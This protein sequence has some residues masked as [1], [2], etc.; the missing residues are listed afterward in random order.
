MTVRLRTPW[1]FASKIIA[2]TSAAATCLIFSNAAAANSHCQTENNDNIIVDT[3]AVDLAWSSTRVNL[4][5][6]TQ[7]QDQLVAYYNATRNMVV[8]HRR[9]TTRQNTYGTPWSFKQLDT[10]LGWDNH[11]SVVVGVSP[12]RHFHVT[13]NMHA[14]QLVYYKTEHPGD[15]R[16]LK[17]VDVM[18]DADL[19][20]RVTY[21]NFFHAD[22][23]TLLLRFRVG[24]SGNGDEVYYRY[25]AESGQWTKALENGFTDGEGQQNAYISS[26]VRGP[27][28]KF[29][30][31]WVWRTDPGSTMNT[32]VSYAR[33]Q[34]YIYWEDAYG[35]PL[36]L[37][38]T[39]G[40]TPV[41]APVPLDNGM[42]N[43]H[44]KVGFDPQGRPLVTYVQYDDNKIAQAYIAR[45]EGQSW[46]QYQL[47][48][49]DRVTH[50]KNRRGALAPTS[51]QMRFSP[52]VNPN[53]TVSVDAHLFGQPKTLMLD[54]ETL[55]L[56]DTCDRQPVPSFLKAWEAQ[57]DPRLNFRWMES[58][59]TPHNDDYRI[60]MSWHVRQG[61]RD[62]AFADIIDPTTLRVHVI[63]NEIIEN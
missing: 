18:V 56:I 4:D 27:D 12:D 23:G 9:T 58:R 47:T 59:G 51:V 42:V 16:T 5:L 1:P 6:L 40:S 48:Q 57:D 34:D 50:A 29:H 2:L 46:K 39:L 43:G 37:P 14:N 60:F 19:E 53:G 54:G 3:R 20:Q 61:N 17:R 7:G 36:S 45:F 8:A 11:N 13:G 24:G 63:K 55:A 10:M 33:T 52:E 32:M 31:A 35:S 44:Q 28:G 25:D 21:P 41:A 30:I 26:P 15:V 38:I 62:R 22:D 49:L